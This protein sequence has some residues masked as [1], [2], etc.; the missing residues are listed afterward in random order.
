VGQKLG[1][2]FVEFG[3]KG[4]EKMKDFS[5]DVASLPLNILGTMAAFTGLSLTFVGL[6][7]DMIHMTT[8]LRQFNAQTG[9]ATEGMDKWDQ[10]ARHVGMSNGVVEGSFNN[11]VN[12]IAQ[13]KIGM[14]DEK[15]I[16][17]FGRMGIRDYW[18]AAPER[19]MAEMRQ[20]FQAARTP[21][22]R[23]EFMQWMAMTGVNPDM[24]LAF[25]SPLSSP[26]SMG[27]MAQQYT[28]DT[29]RQIAEFVRAIGEVTDAFRRDFLEFFKRIEPDLPIIAKGFEQIATA[30]T[31]GIIQ[32]FRGVD[33][34]HKVL[35]T[36]GMIGNL[37][38]EYAGH[39]A[40]QSWLWKPSHAGAGG[41]TVNQHFYGDVDKFD[42]DAGVLDLKS[43]LT[44]TM[45]MLG[46]GGQ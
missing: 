30:M 22:Q 3:I 2:V 45:R 15:M 29:Q 40:A 39:A 12:K 43:T 25:Q 5:K 7:D 37:V 1:E 17:G 20:R 26:G 18:T 42:I 27:R 28:P 21:G 11:L 8:G 36:P 34:M 6:T 24:A 32:F 4:A 46:K 33:T 19:L 44:H 31:M 9:L 14:G 16:M 38:N 41:V 10:V 13:L 23:Q 35:K